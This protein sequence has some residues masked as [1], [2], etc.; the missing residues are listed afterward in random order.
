MSSNPVASLASVTGLLALGVTLIGPV[1][2]DDPCAGFSWNVTH[3]RALFATNAQAFSA[4]RDAVSA[5]M[6]ELNRLYTL[7]LAPREQVQL[8]AATGRKNHG[9][10]TG[11]AGLVRLNVYPP[12]SYRIAIA[13]L[14]RH[15]AR[16]HTHRL[17][18]VRRGARL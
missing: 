18:R 2:A 11:F 1:R 12:G 8:A 13:G 4:G 3:E 7:S 9:A 6:L 17:E 16:Q 14:D 15:R 5:P 10:E